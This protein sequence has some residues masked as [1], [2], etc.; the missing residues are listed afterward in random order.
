VN[1]VKRLG[2]LGY[3]EHYKQPF[4]LKDKFFLKIVLETQE[5]HPKVY[6]LPLN[7]FHCVLACCSQLVILDVGSN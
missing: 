2:G 4:S 1:F 3:M 6:H 5:A 7:V